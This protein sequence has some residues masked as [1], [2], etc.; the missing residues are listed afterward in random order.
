MQ[1]R[2]ALVK[3]GGEVGTAV[4][5]GLWRAGWAVVVAELPRPTVLRR[6]LSL[7]EAAFAGEV[8]R[9]GVLVKRVTSAAA[10][11]EL[12]AARAALPLYVGDAA[13]AARL[14]KPA[15]VVDARMRRHLLAEDQRGEAPLVVGLGPGLCAGGNVDAVIETSPGPLLGQVLWQGAALPHVSR[16]RPEGEAPAEEYAYAPR[17]GLWRT[18]LA[19]GQTVAA[20]ALLGTLDGEFVR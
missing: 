4:A 2:I 5:L 19:I 20:G 12:L 6:Q 3:G 13:E 16:Q 7:A 14:L 15:L 8:T 9:Q 18:P 17:A 11:A 1:Q 10:A